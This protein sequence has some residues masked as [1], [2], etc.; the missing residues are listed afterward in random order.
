MKSKTWYANW[1]DSPYYPIL[2]Q[3]RNEKEARRFI[4]N[5]LELLS[6]PGGAV[7]LDLACGRGRHSIYLN[8]MGYE[9]CGIDLSESRIDEA[10]KSESSTLHF[11]VHDMRKEYGENRFDYILNLF[12][13]FGYFDDESEN[14]EVLS[15][16][17][18]ALK[19]GGFFV[20]DY[21][22]PYTVINSLVDREIVHSHGI[23]FTIKRE[24]EN[25]T[26]VKNIEFED[27][28]E[29]FAFQERVQAFK[30]EDFQRMMAREGLQIMHTFG[31]YD[32]AE[33]I[34]DKSDRLIIIAQN[35]GD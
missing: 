14:R 33:Y 15:T 7:F 24:V 20:L 29:E 16:V 11:E 12:T 13:S 32:L 30:I 35:P 22:N 2:Y 34:P 5:L 17:H 6:P 27:E 19:P 21:L 31:D 8:Q 4:D 9:V 10:K 1:F 23:E 18:T 28:G 25:G 3:H 26:I